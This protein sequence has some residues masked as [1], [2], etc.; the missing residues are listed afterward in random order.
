[1]IVGAGDE[2][3]AAGHARREYAR[4]GKKTWIVDRAGKPRWNDL[5]HGLDWIA[6]PYERGDFSSVT[7]AVGCRPYLKYPWGGVRQQ[8]TD[9]RARDHIG[10]IQF[11]ESE[12]GF[13]MLAPSDYVLIE[14]NV[15][16]RANPN[17]QWG[18][19]RWQTLVDLM[20]DVRWVQTGEK[21]ARQLRGVEFIQ[22]GTFRLA[23]VVL[24][25]ARLSVLPEGGL[26][27]ASAHIGRRAVVLF[28]GVTPVE[29]FGYPS[30]DNIAV[31]E[32]CGN[33]KTCR[34]CALIWESITPQFVRGRV[35]A[36]LCDNKKSAA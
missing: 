30:H 31:G 4:T 22:T 28:G 5:W 21:C 27:H 1:M 34:H 8:F 33:W 17:K 11:T 3:M 20:P 25:R 13:A 16:R 6:L 29:T 36:M 10:G 12:I 14:P 19:D 15:K 18:F 23:A 26:H 7:N 24:S 2:I 32:P 9:W 35:E